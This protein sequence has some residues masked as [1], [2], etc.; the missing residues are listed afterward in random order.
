MCKIQVRQ[1]L[2]GQGMYTAQENSHLEGP[3]HTLHLSIPWTILAVF[4]LSL[5]HDIPGVSYVEGPWNWI[6]Q[7][8]YRWATSGFHKSR[9]T[10]VGRSRDKA[11]LD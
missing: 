10:P 6:P 4:G 8:R 1:A 5:L 7:I 2:V 9:A 11:I 3:D